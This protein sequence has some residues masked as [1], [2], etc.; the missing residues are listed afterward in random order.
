MILHSQVQASFFDLNQLLEKEPTGILVKD[1][2]NCCC[3]SVDN[4]RLK[5]QLRRIWI[6]KDLDELCCFLGAGNLEDVAYNFRRLSPSRQGSG[7]GIDVFS[8]ELGKEPNGGRPAIEFRQGGIL[9]D[10]EYPV[11][12]IKVITGLIAWAV[13]VDRWR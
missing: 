4:N 5:S 8:T 7:T 10:K 6:A 2:F 11:A 1:S 13:D 9:L 12:W 3:D